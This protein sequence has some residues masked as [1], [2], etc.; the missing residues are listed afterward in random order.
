MDEYIGGCEGNYLPKI[1]MGMFVIAMMVFIWYVYLL[2]DDMKIYYVPRQE[3]MCG[4]GDQ[5]CV[6]AGNE[7]MVGSRYTDSKL[8]RTALGY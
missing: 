8:S 6:C 2:L 5:G 4:G 3:S 1:I 7:T